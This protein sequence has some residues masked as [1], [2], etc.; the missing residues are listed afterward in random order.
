MPSTGLEPWVLFGESATL[1]A[2]A[3]HGTTADERE[4]RELARSCRTRVAA[5]LR[6]SGPQVDYPVAGAMLLALGAWSVLRA[7]A[8]PD[9]AARLLA[10]A[11]RFAYNRMIPTLA[12]E[13]IV[14]HAEALAPGRIAAERA[15][16]AGRTAAELPEHAVALLEQL[17]V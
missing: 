17:A 16:L 5:M 3:Y 1:A 14:P 7:P 11:E 6:D 8:T 15:E 10:L 2:Y 9:V 13:R 4:A 12:W